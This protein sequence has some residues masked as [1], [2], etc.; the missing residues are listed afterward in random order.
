[1]ALPVFWTATGGAR[2]GKARAARVVDWAAEMDRGGGGLP[3]ATLFG[4]NRWIGP[5]EYI[6]G[7]I[8]LASPIVFVLSHPQLACV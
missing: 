3:S 4:W 1:V 2:A 7:A 8:S 5:W 6:E